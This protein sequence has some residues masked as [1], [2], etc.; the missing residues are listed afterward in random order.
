VIEG[1][2]KGGSKRERPSEGRSRGEMSVSKI[3][4]ICF[5]SGALADEAVGPVRTGARVLV[6]G[7]LR[8]HGWY[9]HSVRPIR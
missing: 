6:H 5:S 3:E 9:V 1:R 2:K 7:A 8:S 4:A